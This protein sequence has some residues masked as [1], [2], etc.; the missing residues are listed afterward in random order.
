MLFGAAR[1]RLFLTT[2]NESAGD[3]EDRV[4]VPRSFPQLLNGL[5]RREDYQLEIAASGLFLDVIHDRETAVSTRADHK[6]TAF[7]RYF[8]CDRQRRMPVGIAE[9]LRRLLLPLPDFA[10]VDDDIML[11]RHSI[12]DDPAKREILDLHD[13]LSRIIRA[14]LFR[15]TW[16]AIEQ[17]SAL[18]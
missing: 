11:V 14:V 1:A 9:S 10:V 18:R 2:G 4:R 12:D 7:P 17:R 5:S 6:P 16:H 15:E 13:Y 3:V 8:L